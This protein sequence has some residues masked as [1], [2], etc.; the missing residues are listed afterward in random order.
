MYIPEKRGPEKSRKKQKKGD[1]FIFLAEKRAQ[2]RGQI[3]FPGFL[4]QR[5]K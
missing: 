1:R 4:G 5:L 3:Y 2:K